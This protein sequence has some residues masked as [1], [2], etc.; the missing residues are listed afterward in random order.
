MFYVQPICRFLVEP[1][2]LLALTT[3]AIENNGNAKLVV[4]TFTH[5]SKAN[6]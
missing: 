4:P 5:R 2:V 6:N 1:I 3:V